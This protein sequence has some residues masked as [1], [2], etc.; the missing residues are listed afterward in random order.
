MADRLQR[1]GQATACAC[2][3]FVCQA[4]VTEPASLATQ[5]SESRQISAEGQ[6]P[7]EANH[8]KGKG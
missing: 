8:P 1:G 7:T 3:G 5:L 6:V 4:P 2:R